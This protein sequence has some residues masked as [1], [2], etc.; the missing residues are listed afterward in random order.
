MIVAAAVLRHQ[1]AVVERRG[2]DGVAHAADHVRIDLAVGQQR[3]DFET[4]DAAGDGAAAD[5]AR[6]AVDVDVR[7][8]FEPLDERA[9]GPQA[10]FGQDPTC[11]AAA[12]GNDDGFLEAERVDDALAIEQR[13]IAGLD[14]CVGGSVLVQPAG[15]HAGGDDR[16]ERHCQSTTQR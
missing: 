6:D 2:V 14:V 1:R 11:P 10:V 15:K 13:R 3:R 12:D 8:R 4:F 5:E 7:H 16:R 9:H